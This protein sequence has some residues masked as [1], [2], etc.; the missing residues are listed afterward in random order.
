MKHSLII[1]IILTFIMGI[2]A[3]PATG[4]VNLHLIAVLPFD[5]G[6]IKQTWGEKYNLGK[7]VA[8]E[9][10][11]AL[12]A[13]NRFR[14]IERAEIEKV[15]DE[16]DLEK[17]G[18][19]D[20]TTAAKI[21]KILGVQY[22]IIGRITE[23]S[24][25]KDDDILVNPNHHNPMG[26]MVTRATSRVAID[27]RLVNATTAE[28]LT[29]V[30]GIGKKATVNLGMI[31]KEGGVLFGDK[32]FKKS[33]LGRALR[34]AVNST[35]RQ[36]AVKAYDG[37]AP[38]TITGMIAYVSTERIIINVGKKHG[39]EPG[40]IFKVAHKLENVKDP[41]TGQVI[42]EVTE[43]VA[44]ILVTEVKEKSATCKIVN[45]N[46]DYKIAI[47]DLIESKDPVKLVLPELPPLEDVE[48]Q[49]PRKGREFR[50]YAERMVLGEYTDE[51]LPKEDENKDSTISFIGG[52]AIF[53]RFKLV[54]EGSLDG[55]IEDP[56]RKLAISEYK[57]G[58]NLNPVQDAQI[59]LFIAK[60]NL[61]EKSGVNELLHCSSWVFGA[62]LE[63]KM[64]EK[65]YFE[66]S[67][68]YGASID[69][70]VNGDDRAGGN[71]AIMKTKVS[72]YFS[73][74]AAVYGQ[75]R[76]Y[77]MKIVDDQDLSGITAGLVFKY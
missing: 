41:V 66:L 58:Y 48:E 75:Y 36:L 40:M 38:L 70:R 68:G 3:L 23:F 62:D 44:E 17:D 56:N 53:G 27:A 37:M 34:Q 43:P 2:I 67:Y 49:G 14:L 39:V 16:Q 76:S 63:Y 60:F 4:A 7:G 5:D 18:V 72:Y 69:Y 25:K 33:D 42:G 45:K 13:T 57:L 8:D 73:D 65:I 54:G 51:S 29:S 32:D 47:S 31:T 10:V 22:L 11:T 77:M 71:L 50:L 21:G 28:I 74:H 61:G 15:L 52:Q 64:A 19:I 26:M 35:A 59:E 6:S 55:E 20:P 24:T 30:T 12:L 46:N 9:L 1:L